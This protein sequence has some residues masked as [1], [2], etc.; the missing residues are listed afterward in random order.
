MAHARDGMC[1]INLPIT[2]KLDTN[3]R[4]KACEQEFNPLVV[5]GADVLTEPL[6][7]ARPAQWVDQL[8]RSKRMRCLMPLTVTPSPLSTLGLYL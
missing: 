5:G 1:H 8:S 7:R 6:S 2:Y 4:R 3:L